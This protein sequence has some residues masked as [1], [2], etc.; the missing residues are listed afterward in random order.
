MIVRPNPGASGDAVT[1]AANKTG[2]S[3]NE[4]GY[5]AALGKSVQDDG[6]YIVVIGW[7]SVAVRVAHI[8]DS[9]FLT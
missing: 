1:A 2:D 4:N 3:F 5:P 7:P 6:V 9:P 8:S